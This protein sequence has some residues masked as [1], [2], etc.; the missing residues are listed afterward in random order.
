[1]ERDSADTARRQAERATVSL[2]MERAL[3]QC[4][5][6][7]STAGLLWLARTLD[8]AVASGATDLEPVLRSNIAAWAGRVTAP[9]LG[10]FPRGLV[11][12]L[13][14]SA[15]GR[16]L[17]TTRSDFKDGKAGPGEAQ[18]WEAD[19][20]RRVGRPMNDSEPLRS[21]ALTPDGG[22]VVTC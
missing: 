17:V 16:Y 5:Q 7:E 11:T 1:R 8:D 14:Y 10:P 4:E 3:N 13:A 20:W 9:Q 22:R 21:V 15:D 18:V 19:G 6:G 12:A 2:R